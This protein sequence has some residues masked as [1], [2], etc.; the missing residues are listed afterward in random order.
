MENMNYSAARLFQVF[1]THF[2]HDQAIL[3]QHNPRQIAD[4]A[5]GGRMGNAPPPSDDGWNYRGQGFSQLTG[6]D[7]YVALSKIVKM[8]LINHPELIRDPDHALECGVGD[9][10]MC[11][12]LPWAM[13]DDLLAV[14]SLLNVGHIVRVPSRINGF[15]MRKNWL[16]LWKHV[17]GI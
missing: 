13:K 6:K 12:C 1:P 3:Y 7:N 2:T 10:V 17:L 15:S 14:S 9:F 16:G 8:D 4:H 11:G 5:Y